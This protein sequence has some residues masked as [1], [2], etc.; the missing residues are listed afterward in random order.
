MSKV[1]WKNIFAGVQ[2]IVF[3][4]ERTFMKKAVLHKT[5]LMH[6][7]AR[8]ALRDLITTNQGNG[9]ERAFVARNY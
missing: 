6:S 1:S 8:Q 4:N 2:L 5:S 3:E 7:K 9:S